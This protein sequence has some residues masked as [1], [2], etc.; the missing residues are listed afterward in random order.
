MKRVQQFA[1]V[2]IMGLAVSGSVWGMAAP[3]PWG[4]T[5]IVVPARFSVLQVAFDVANVTRSELVAYQ[6]DAKSPSPVLDYWTG[7]EWERIS[8]S[9]YER[10]TFVRRPVTQFVIVGTEDLLPKVLVAAVSQWC[11]DVR[12]VS[13]LDKTGLINAFGKIFSFGRSEWEWFAKRYN[14]SLV[15]LN[16]DRRRQSWYD[17]DYY[18]DEWAHRWRWLRRPHNRDYDLR[19]RGSGGPPP[20]RESGSLE[21]F[22]PEPRGESSIQYGEM[23][24]TVHA[25]TAEQ[26]VREEPE[27][28]G[29]EVE[30]AP[31]K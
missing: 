19:E 12:V 5:V 17:R 1:S 3:R 27:D 15:D 24:G 16:A 2:L 18:D 4:T 21:S 8:L 25:E 22:S 10:A 28:T 20:P 13:D 31:V 11:R 9:D 30:E 14:L 23:Q 29:T 6:G 7:Q 26:A